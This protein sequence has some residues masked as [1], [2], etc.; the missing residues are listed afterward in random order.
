MN[1]VIYN[2]FSFCY[3]AVHL[4][5]EPYFFI[6]THFA[7]QGSVFLAYN[8]KVEYKEV[9]GKLVALF[10]EDL[11]PHAIFNEEEICLPIKN[12]LR[13]TGFNNVFTAYTDRH[14][15]IDAKRN[16]LYLKK[17]DLAFYGNSHRSSRLEKC[18]WQKRRMNYAVEALNYFDTIKN[19]E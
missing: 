11:T 3:K 15:F 13:M 5:L 17:M 6:R 10:T 16:I 4:I 18:F 19:V 8:Y 1:N 9:N 12:K 14:F 2:V 7:P